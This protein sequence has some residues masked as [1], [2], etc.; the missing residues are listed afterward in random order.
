MKGG[1]PKSCPR[2]RSKPVAWTKPLRVDYC[3]DCLPGGPYTPP[4]CSRCGSTKDYYSAGLC[5]LCHPKAPQQPGSCKDCY[6]WGVVRKHKWL[7]WGCRSWRTKFEIGT[8]ICC[9]REITVNDDGVCRLCWRQAASLRWTKTGLSLTDANQYGQQLFLANL[10]QRGKRAAPATPYAKLPPPTQTPP[11][12]VAHRQLALLDLPRDLPAGLRAGFPPPPDPEAAEFLFSR[13]REHAQQHGWSYSTTK[14]VCRG[15]EILL[16]LQD[17]PDAPILTSLINQLP[18]IHLP[19]KLITEF[20]DS[21]ALIEDDVTPATEI[22]FETRVAGLPGTMVDELRLWWTVLRDGHVT[23]PRSRPRVR[24]TAQIKLRWASPTLRHWAN[25][26]VQSLREISRDDVVAVLPAS[27]NDRYT[28]GAGLRSIFKVLKTHKVVFSDPTAKLRL[29]APERRQPLP[30]DLALMKEGLTSPD[31]SRAVMTA[32]LAFHGLS[33]GQLRNLRLTDI[34]DGRLHFDDRTILLAEPVRVRLT[35][36]LNYR[37]QRWP[38]TANPHLFVHYRSALGTKPVGTRWPGLVLGAAARDIRTDR[39]L[40][41]VRATG[42]DV[43]RICDLFGLS[44]GAAVRYTA[45]LDHPGLHDV[46]TK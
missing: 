14:K 44:V 37:N 38:R 16:S 18:S 30:A 33:S 15:V 9:R 40:D 43:R 42:G 41:E 45:I 1:A 24:V 21:Y 31:P 29:G 19:A 46:A 2:C 13:A 6:A 12:V 32:L 26:G 7:C 11:R 10:H 34:R 28:I 3:Y 35:A 20:L 27:G 25:H 23:V 36:Y 5:V 8:C 17:T 39:I 4:P 22:W